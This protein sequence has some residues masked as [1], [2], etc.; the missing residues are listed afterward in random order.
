MSK[1]QTT[2]TI[3]QNIK[4]NKSEISKIN[5]L[6]EQYL[7]I[8]WSEISGRKNQ[9]IINLNSIKPKINLN[10]SSSLNSLKHYS[11]NYNKINYFQFIEI[12]FS[13]SQ[14]LCFILKKYYNY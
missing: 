6:N 12:L 10:R 8:L 13:L 7:N 11:L 3:K 14:I 4:L 1:L 9:K 2:S 5:L